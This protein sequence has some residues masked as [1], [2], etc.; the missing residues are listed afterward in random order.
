MPR[1]LDESEIAENWK[2]VRRYLRR[3]FLLLLLPGLAIIWGA[4]YGKGLLD[5]YAQKESEYENAN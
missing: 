5:G 3:Y 4:G 1:P 2:Q